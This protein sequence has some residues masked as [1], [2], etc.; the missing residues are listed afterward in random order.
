MKNKQSI[1]NLDGTKPA[2]IEPLYSHLRTIYV[3]GQWI[4]YFGDVIED[5]IINRR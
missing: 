4:N 2:I 3:L 1:I 5:E